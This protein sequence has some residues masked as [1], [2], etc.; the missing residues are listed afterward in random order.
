MKNLK[1]SILTLTG[2]VCLAV[3]VLCTPVGLLPVQAAV[4]DT[5]T[6]EPNADVLEW[7][8]KVVDGK[9]YRRLFNYTTDSWVGDWEYVGEV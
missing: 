2:V 8:F 7:R 1:K 6:M 4:P 5:E 3:A 9:L